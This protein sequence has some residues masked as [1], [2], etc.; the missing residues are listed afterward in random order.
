MIMMVKMLMII[1]MI[2]ILIKNE[3]VV[4]THNEHRDG[5]NQGTGYSHK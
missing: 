5:L 4:T 2:M 3:R 1:L